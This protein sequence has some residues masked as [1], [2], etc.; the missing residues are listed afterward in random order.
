LFCITGGHGPVSS[1]CPRKSPSR[2][3]QSEIARRPEFTN[4][5]S[6]LTSHLSPFAPLI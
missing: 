6:L 4:D 3:T 1:D 5:K 2:K